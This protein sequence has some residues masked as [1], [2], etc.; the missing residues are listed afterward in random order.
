MR[1]SVNRRCE[2][3]AGCAL[4]Q[5]GDV[6]RLRSCSADTYIGCRQLSAIYSTYAFFI[7]HYGNYKVKIKAAC[8]Q[9]EKVLFFPFFCRNNLSMLLFPSYSGELVAAGRFRQLFG[10]EV[11]V[12]N[13][14][15]VLEDFAAQI[16]WISFSLKIN[17]K[18]RVGDHWFWGATVGPGAGGA[19]WSSLVLIIWKGNNPSNAGI[20]PS[21]ALG[22][23]LGSP[24][25][26][27]GDGFG[28]TTHGLRLRVY[29]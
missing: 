6:R 29:K 24:S 12:S 26:P 22:M 15:I 19:R 27:N 10:N 25:M 13:W 9:Q 8:H 4:L 16:S 5:L 17:A 18:W 7:C 14:E 21:C 11:W 23:G 2:P 20:A 28:V 1:Q 3:C